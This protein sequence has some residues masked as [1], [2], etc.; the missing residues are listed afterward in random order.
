MDFSFF[1]IFFSSYRI[2]SF[3]FFTPKRIVFGPPPVG[4]GASAG[5]PAEKKKGGGGGGKL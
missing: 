2:N 3:L 5:A 1:H 4:T